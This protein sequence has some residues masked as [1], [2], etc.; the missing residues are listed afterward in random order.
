MWD[1][2]EIVLLFD[3]KSGPSLEELS[4]QVP[5]LLIHDKLIDKKIQP[6]LSVHDSV[7]AATYKHVSIKSTQN[8]ATVPCIEF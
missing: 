4:L 5:E 7:S 3:S 6:E 2:R 8:I 1:L